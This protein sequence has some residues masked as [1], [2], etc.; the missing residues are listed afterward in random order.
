[1]CTNVWY[2][3]HSEISSLGTLNATLLA[4]LHARL[5][6]H[7]IGTNKVVRKPVDLPQQFGLLHHF[8]QILI[9]PVFWFSPLALCIFSLSLNSI[10]RQCD[11]NPSSSRQILLLCKRMNNSITNSEIRILGTLNATLPSLLQAQLTGY[12]TSTNK[13]VLKPFDLLQWLGLLQ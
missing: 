1:M 6:D 13:V 3:T 9:R 11:I 8:K 7:G 5:D 10:H 12:S 2:Y 4:L